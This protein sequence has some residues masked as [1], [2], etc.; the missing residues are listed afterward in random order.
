MN[1]TLNMVVGNGM[2]ARR[3]SAYSDRDDVLIFASGVS[4]SKENRPA[5]FEREKN[6]VETTIAQSPDRL[7]VYFSTCS[8]ADP[9]EQGSLYTQH[10]L[11]LEN[12][13]RQHCP[14]Y[15]LIRA[16]NVVGQTENPHTVFNFFVNRIQSGEPFQVWQ[17]ACRNLIDVDDV[18][19]VVTDYIRRQPSE[20]NQT[21]NVANP[22]SVKPLEIVRAIENHLGLK[23]NYELVDK[24]R[25]FDIDT[26]QSAA[27][28]RHK[29]ADLQ[30][31]RYLQYLLQKYY[32]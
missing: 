20:W 19:L 24:G 2:I 31:E 15:L 29:L 13:I 28:L 22:F 10:K 5:A 12:H 11:A 26:A 16:S 14:H 30:P 21:I 7:F 1:T 32:R 9:T 18:Y 8:V 25:P 27:A 3:F 6:L 23:A 4:N 17:H